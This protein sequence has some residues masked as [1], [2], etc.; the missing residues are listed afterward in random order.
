MT[1][2]TL[3]VDQSHWLWHNSIGHVLLFISGL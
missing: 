2:K 1:L 3:K